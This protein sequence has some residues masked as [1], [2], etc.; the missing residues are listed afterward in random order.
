MHRLVIIFGVAIV[1]LAVALPG[2]P[3][4]GGF[5]KP[6]FSA[7]GMYTGSWNGQSNDQ[8]PQYIQQCPL[9]LTLSQN[10]NAGYPGD[11]LVEGTALVDYSCLVLPE[12]I[13]TPPP[14]T[15]NVGGVLGD[16]GKMVL[17]SAGCGTGL[18]LVLSFDGTGQDTNADKFMDAYS[19]TWSFSLLLAGVE[20]FTVEGTFDLVAG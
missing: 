7:A 13:D 12:W 10:Y 3:P 8:Q 9:T 15:V 2:C 16:D 4:A 18:C 5:P 11:H 20:P 14:S 19:G 17:V 6:P 1:A